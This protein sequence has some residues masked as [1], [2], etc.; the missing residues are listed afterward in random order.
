MIL[1]F[2]ESSGPLCSDC[3]HY[4]TNSWNYIIIYFVGRALSK[5]L[6]I[7]GLPF[8]HSICYN[9]FLV[10]KDIRSGYK[11]ESMN[12]KVGEKLKSIRTARTLSLDDAAA[13]T[14]VSKP[15]LGQQI[16]CGNLKFPAPTVRKRSGRGQKP[17]GYSNQNIHRAFLSCFS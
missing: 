12:L 8:V 16:G 3:N 2:L 6:S 4:N 1:S 15:M 5:C 17:H 9:R 11:M 7:L 14:G 13:L 10:Y